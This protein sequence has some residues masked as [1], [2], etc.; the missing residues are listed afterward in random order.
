MEYFFPDSIRGVIKALIYTFRDIH[1]K[2]FAFNI[3]TP[4]PT[5]LGLISL[6][7]KILEYLLNLVLGIRYMTPG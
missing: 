3:G 2:N 5:P 1:V 4:P 6:G 7:Q